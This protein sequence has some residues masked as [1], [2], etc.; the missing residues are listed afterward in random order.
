MNFPD[1]TVWYIQTII[2]SSQQISGIATVSLSAYDRAGNAIDTLDIN[3]RD[4]LLIDNRFPS[5]RL[6]YVN[7]SQQEWLENEGKGGDL[8]QITGNFNKPINISVPLL[9][10][11]FADSTN[12]SFIGKLPD[13][14]SNGDSTYIWSFVL[15]SNLEDH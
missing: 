5:C 12:S 9:D 14:N 11:E 6:E 8:I 4:T 7:L 10:I 2:P 1:S 3:N 15:P 13:S